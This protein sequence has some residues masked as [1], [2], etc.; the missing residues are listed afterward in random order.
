MALRLMEALLA[1]PREV[2][3]NCFALLVE[4]SDETFLTI[5]G[6][7]ARVFLERTLKPE[8]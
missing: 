4:F 3:W 1:A 5:Y 7:L 8:G 2:F 6:W